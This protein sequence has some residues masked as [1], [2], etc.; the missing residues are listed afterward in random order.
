MKS[1]QIK[2]FMRI[3]FSITRI[4]SAFSAKRISSSAYRN[5]N[6]G[7][8]E[9]KRSMKGKKSEPVIFCVLPPLLALQPSKT[10]KFCFLYV[11]FVIHFQR[12]LTVAF[13]SQRLSL[14]LSLWSSSVLFP[15][16][17]PRFA[18]PFSFLIHS[19]SFIFPLFFIYNFF[20]FLEKKNELEIIP[21][22]LFFLTHKF[23]C[24]VNYVVKLFFFFFLLIKISTSEHC[25][26]FSN[27]H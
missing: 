26:L 1:T 12:V 3:T 8:V 9:I 13:L 11:P 20:P 17:I 22:V 18:S 23:L 15:L 14:S 7:T 10:L 5:S 19:K 2:S 27:V 24:C 21:N 4:S 16:A 25:L 6:S